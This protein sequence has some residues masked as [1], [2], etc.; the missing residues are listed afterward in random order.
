MTQPLLEYGQSTGAYEQHSSVAVLHGEAG[1]NYLL[2][3]SVLPTPLSPSPKPAAIITI[4]DSDIVRDTFWPCSF[5]LAKVLMGAG[6]LALPK[7]YSILGLVLGTVLMIAI[8]LL[9][10]VSL[11]G[12]TRA[13]EA[14][15]MPTYGSMV[16]ARCGRVAKV[17]LQ[18]AVVITCFGAMV[19]YLVVIG[20]IL[21]GNAP[22][23]GGLLCELTHMQ[24]SHV[25][26][27]HRRV[28]LGILSLC[29]LGPL[30][31][32]NS[33]A[34]L[35]PVNII[36][37]FS[38]ALFGVLSIVLAG[39]ALRNG[40]ASKIYW[41]PDW[42]SMGQTK[43]V[44]GLTFASVIPIILGAD[45]CH[46]SLPPLIPLLKPYS[47]ARMNKLIGVALLSCNVIYMTTSV[48]SWIAFGDQLS[49]D[50]LNN[51]TTEAM[52]A[53][54]G[55]V[56]AQILAAILRLGFLSALIGSF[57]LLMWPMREA[58]L[59]LWYGRSEAAAPKRA[60][61]FALLLLT[62][63]A[64]VGVH[65][66]FFALSLVGSTS[67][68]LVGFIFPA[69]LMLSEPV[70]RTWRSAITRSLALFICILGVSLFING[71]IVPF[72]R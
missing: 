41:F 8:A 39:E 52:S 14:T 54:V 38:T 36:G 29:V 63:L 28:I 53:V 47:E 11:G 21:V 70:E 45:V 33:M 26:W 56:L 6:M 32:L 68:T 50:V 65:S 24:P 71:L 27:M 48:C 69:L 15:K 67:A 34:L 44:V 37:M 30:V 9:S 19:V 18:V 61:A 22:D 43:F 1:T 16:N 72:L 13:W 66:I 35:A 31:S 64:A 10:W 23:Y 3:H 7:A 25:W 60:V 20:D 62:Y 2:S 55:L 42:E 49:D 59:E 57:V 4:E 5:N 40:Q 46:Q 12:L 58:L 17:A 51:F